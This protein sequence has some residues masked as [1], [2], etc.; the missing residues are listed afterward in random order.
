MKLDHIRTML[1]ARSSGWAFP[2]AIKRDAM[3]AISE[4]GVDQ[5]AQAIRAGELTAEALAEA[6]PGGLPPG[7]GAGAGLAGGRASQLN[8]FIGLGP[9]R[10]RAAA[11][12]ADEQR[13]RGE[14]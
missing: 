9:G 4:L 10:V 8:A 1:A 6:L 13:R 2:I 14:R 3:T 5:A 7:R 11:V 12:R